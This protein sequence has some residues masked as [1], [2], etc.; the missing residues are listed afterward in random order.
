MS[1]A[2]EARERLAARQAAL[3]RSLADRA[4]PPEGFDPARIRA[5]ADALARKRAPGVARA[6]PAL[7][8]ALGARFGPLF[9]AFAA[10]ARPPR[11]GGPLADGRAF[12][13]AL[14]DRGELPES[15]RVEVMAVALR[16]APRPDGLAPRRGPALAVGLLH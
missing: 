13:R 14:A 12:A 9:A 15:A 16:H 6:W 4:A 5:T 8:G 7:A 2:P 11:R 10:A 1:P 3:V